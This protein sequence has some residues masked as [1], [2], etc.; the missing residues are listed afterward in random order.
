MAT[1]LE[2]LST[3]LQSALDLANSLP[4]AITL[5]ELTNPGSAAT[6]LEGTEMLDADGKKVTGSIETKDSSNLT[7]SGATVNVPAGYYADDAMIEIETTEM[8]PLYASVSTNGVLTARV[9][10]LDDGYIEAD[11]QTYTQQLDT[12][13][14]TTIT[15][16]KSSQTA[17]EAGKYTT[18]AVT[19]GAIPDEYI[20]TSDA[21]ATAPHILAGETAYV[22]GVKV[23]GMMVDRTSS[24]IETGVFIQ[25]G[26]GNT[27]FRVAP[28]EGYY[29]GNDT[30]TWSL[31]QVVVDPT[32]Q[33]QFFNAVDTGDGPYGDV[34][35]EP[36][37]D[38]Y[39]DVSNVTATAARTAAGDVFVDADGVEQTGKLNIGEVI[40][41]YDTDTEE[42]NSGTEKINAILFSPSESYLMISDETFGTA[43]PSKVL[44][45]STFT[46]SESGGL[47]KS[48]TMP[49]NG[50]LSSTIDGLETKSVSIPKGYTDGGTV[51]LDSTIDD[52]ADSQAAQIA[53]IKAMLEGK[54][55]GGGSA[56][57]TCTVTVTNSVAYRTPS[58]YYSY[59]NGDGLYEVKHGVFEID[60]LNQYAT[61]EN[62]LIGS[63]VIISGASATIPAYTF[64]GDI[65][66]ATSFGNSTHIFIVRSDGSIII[67]DDD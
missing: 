17:V 3:K 46:S 43:D 50:T 53:E 40:F 12:Q 51:A 19:V 18:G 25:D 28:A 6:M 48:G 22:D 11:T 13:S 55:V 66:L 31:A 56:V 14:A 52:T 2:S 60:G 27:C 21:N 1:K 39:Q 47:A 16:T 29:D 45:D 54:S 41:S 63:L 24:D 15:P 8:A 23:T 42:Y 38:E 61:L 67:R 65:E 44:A 20:D 26:S 34:I 35:V 57:E 36:I 59:V 30:K 4:D 58:F 62:V 37:P 10:V 33:R 5:D 7:A 32:K 64:T 49:N 9:S